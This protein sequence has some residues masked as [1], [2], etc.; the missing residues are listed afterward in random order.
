MPNFTFSPY[1]PLAVPAGTVATTWLAE[2]DP[3]VSVAT[4]VV[5]PTFSNVITGT[6]PVGNV[7]V[8]VT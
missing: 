7:P 3:G 8:N 1:V 6:L 5:L 2:F 4:A